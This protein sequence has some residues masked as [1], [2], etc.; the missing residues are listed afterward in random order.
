MGC[1]LPLV[2]DLGHFAQQMSMEAPSLSTRNMRFEGEACTGAADWRS[3]RDR[4][5]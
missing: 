5:K 1:A 3:Y 2:S 4:A